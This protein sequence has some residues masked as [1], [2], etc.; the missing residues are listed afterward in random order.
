ML[1]RDEVVVVA[2]EPRPDGTRQMPEVGIVIPA[3]ASALGKA[4]LAFS[5]EP[6]TGPL[7]SMTGDTVTDTATLAEQL[8][9]VRATGIASEVEEAILGECALAA[10]VFD[11]T[12]Q[13]AGA[14]SLVVPAGRWPL[15]PEA[16][17]ALRDTARTVSRELGAP[18]W[19]PRT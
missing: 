19:P 10:T 9:Q 11:T 8:V 16:V 1:L 3:H 17:D 2:H 12:E 18:V 4:L 14:I 7:R 13:P 5:P 15:P 6:L